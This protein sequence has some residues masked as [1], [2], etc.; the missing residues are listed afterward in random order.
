MFVS[1]LLV[2]ALAASVFLPG[3]REFSRHWACVG[4]L[5][6]G[7]LAVYVVL[8]TTFFTNRAGSSAAQ[9]AITWL[10]QQPVQ[11]GSQPGPA[12]SSSCLSELEPFF[13]GLPCST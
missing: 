11:R 8:F 10:A 7:D 4:R 12:T 3:N 13:I 9:W 2:S 5:R 6:R 1:L